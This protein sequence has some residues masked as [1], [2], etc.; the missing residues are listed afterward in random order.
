MDDIKKELERIE[1]EHGVIVPEAVVEAA[2]DPGCPLHEHFTWDDSKA[3]ESWR[4]VEARKLIARV[5]VEMVG[6]Q[7][8]TY[9][10]RAFTHLS[11][12]KTG[13]RSLSNIT[14]DASLS[15]TLR[16]DLAKDLE[17]LVS[18]YRSTVAVINEPALFETIDA[19][20]AGLLTQVE[21]RKAS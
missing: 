18:K 9:N 3:A 4:I 21:Q 16:R 17:R 1:S 6:Q 2:R 15:E 8:S 7:Q 19:Y 14:A 20:V 11:T 12:D 13:Y 10:V 5:R